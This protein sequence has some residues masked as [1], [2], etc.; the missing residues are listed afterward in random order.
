MPF[1]IHTSKRFKCAQI[2]TPPRPAQLS[3]ELSWFFNCIVQLLSFE[4]VTGMDEGM[5]E[6]VVAYAS[7]D[8]KIAVSQH[9]SL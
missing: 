1:S 8:F 2:D 4:N 7:I 5:D 9:S 3:S 6:S